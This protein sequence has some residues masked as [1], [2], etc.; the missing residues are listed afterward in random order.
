MTPNARKAIQIKAIFFLLSDLKKT[1][2]AAISSDKVVI[3]LEMAQVLKLI[4]DSGFHTIGF[5]FST[6]FKNLLSLQFNCLQQ[7][8]CPLEIAIKRSR[9]GSE[10]SMQRFGAYLYCISSRDVRRSPPGTTSCCLHF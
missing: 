3:N 5:H 7:S 4:E 8:F 10:I 1:E 9:F 6:V 2:I